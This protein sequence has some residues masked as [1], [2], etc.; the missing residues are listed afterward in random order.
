MNALGW[1]SR[2]KVAKPPTTTFEPAPTPEIQD[3]TLQDL[4]LLKVAVSWQEA[5][6]VML[7]L[8]GHLSDRTQFPDARA[9]V[10]TEI[11]ETRV[12]SSRGANG[13]PVRLA[14]YLLSELLGSAS[15]PP[16]LR[17]AIEQNLTAQPRHATLDEFATALA[18][19]ER[20]GRRGDVAAV[21]GRAHALHTKA[22]ADLELDRLRARAA[23]EQ[24]IVAT[25]PPAPSPWRTRAV[26]FGAIAALSIVIAAGAMALFAMAF[27]PP[28]ARDDAGAELDPS[29]PLTTL[30]A[31][32]GEAKR[33]VEESI[34]KILSPRPP[35]EAAAPAPPRTPSRASRPPRSGASVASGTDVGSPASA[36]RNGPTTTTAPSPLVAM[37]VSARDI[38][39]SALRESSTAA[40]VEY[41][42]TAVVV[43]PAFTALDNVQPATL[44]RP[45]LPSRL[46]DSPPAPDAS[47]LDMIIDQRGRVEFVRL[48]AVRSQVNEKMLVSAAKAW[49]FEPAMRDGQPVRYRMRVQISE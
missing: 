12:T 29:T 3:L 46:I 9:V 25:Q 17:A 5:V 8:I 2:S 41:E 37:I 13:N 10:L 21:Y 33:L 15:S 36:E 48:E 23:R 1:L 39:A 18:Y 30:A 24:Q 42:A 47:F 16:E 44:V 7:E 40:P 27:A 19:F 22:A 31:A 35:S 11:G 20:P 49:L 43:G 26:Q 4:T 28:P 38:A 6:A 14:A 45:Q 34:T 32:G